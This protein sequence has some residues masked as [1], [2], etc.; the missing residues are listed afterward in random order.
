M[1]RCGGWNRICAGSYVFILDSPDAFRFAVSGKLLAI[2]S[3]AGA[4]ARSDRMRRFA[5]RP[6]ISVEDFWTL[7]SE[8]RKLMLQETSYGIF[9]VFRPKDTPANATVHQTNVAE[10]YYP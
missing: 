8:G 7:R 10:T 3:N 1:K 4:T 9:G 6:P 2:L 5:I